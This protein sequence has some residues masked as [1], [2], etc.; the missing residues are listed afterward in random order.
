M[1]NNETNTVVNWKEKTKEEM[2]EQIYKYC[3]NGIRAGR[4][5]IPREWLAQRKLSI[6][7]TFAVFNSGQ[8]HHGKEQAFKEALADSGFIKVS[9]QTSN[10]ESLPYTVFGNF[11][12]MF[13]L[14]N[15][16][17]QIVN[18]YAIGI[19][20]NK[21]AF[22]NGE[23]IYPNYPQASTKKLFIT[24]N[25]LDAATLL[26]TKILGKEEAVIALNEGELLEQHIQAIK[27]LKNLTE[28]IQIK[29][30]AS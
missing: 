1:K 20:N 29:V 24:D 2:Y 23:G 28:I 26:E 21:T 14:R 7:A 16:E 10:C 17:N 4:T 13:P 27:E 22:L 30:K 9:N 8:I 6:D 19:K 25:I 18:F 5:K 3:A 12:V 11:S 15:K